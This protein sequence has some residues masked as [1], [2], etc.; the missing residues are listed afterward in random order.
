MGATL[1][2]LGFLAFLVIVMTIAYRI[3]RGPVPRH[4]VV[5]R[6][7]ADLAA[8]RLVHRDVEDVLDRYRNQLDEVGEALEV[9]VR[10]VIRRHD[11]ELL[12]KRET[13]GNES[14]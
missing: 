9:E 8:A 2:V 5:R 6:L 4:R 3:H 7:R 11:R 14:D 10:G 13:S 12:E 1:G